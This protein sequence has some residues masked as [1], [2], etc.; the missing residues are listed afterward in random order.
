MP[1]SRRDCRRPWLPRRCWVPL[2]I[3]VGTALVA[4]STRAGVQFVNCARGPGGSISCDTV[5]T[6]NTLMNDIDAREGLLQQASPG[7]S[8][9]DPYAGY[10]E[11]F[12]G[13]D[14]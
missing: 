5:P 13:D 4:S 1:A 8:E 12:G 9:F 6:G 14:T 10:S 7:W 11:D 2:L 3:W